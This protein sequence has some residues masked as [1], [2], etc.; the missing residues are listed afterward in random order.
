MRRAPD[1]LAAP[2]IRRL[3]GL[4]SPGG[5]RARLS[6][7]IFHRVLPAKDPLF[8]GEPDVAGFEAILRSVAEWFDV[9]PLDEAVARR[10]RGDLPARALAIT[11]DDGYADN[12]TLATPILR[13]LGL[14]ATFF[15]ATGFLDGGRMWNDS[16]IAAVRGAQG[17]SLDLAALGLGTHDVS[18]VEAKRAAIGTLLPKLKYEAPERREAIAEEVLVRSGSPRPDELMMTTP[19]VRALANA[20]MGIGAHTVRH[21]ILARVTADEARASIAASR[22][23]LEAIVGAPVRLFAYPNGK[24]GTDY[25]RANVEAVRDLGFKAAVTTAPGVATAATSAFELPRFTPWDRQHWRFGLRLAQNLM[26]PVAAAA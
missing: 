21:P 8:P 7:L 24:P 9:L 6:I 10:E 5:A 22:D 16:V 1:R 23:T 14:H 13:R 11:F 18:T 4:L 17:S 26:R 2:W 15:I 19:Q 20:G 12:L 3:N 25:T